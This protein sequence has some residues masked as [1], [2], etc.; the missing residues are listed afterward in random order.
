MWHRAVTGHGMAFQRALPAAVLP[1]PENWIHDQWIFLVGAAL[2]RVDYTPGALGNNLC[3]GGFAYPIS[4][5]L[6]RIQLRC[7]S[8]KR[9]NN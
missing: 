9:Q 1:F 6:L 7:Y 3:A 5:H 8:K 2:G 4:K